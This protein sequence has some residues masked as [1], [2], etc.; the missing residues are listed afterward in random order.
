VKMNEQLY[1]TFLEEMQAL[2][3]FR[4]GYAAEHPTTP[5]QPDDPDVRRMVE[6]LAFFSARSRQASL[7]TLLTHRLRLFRQFLPYLLDPLPAMGMLQAIPT[8]KLAEPVELPRGTE[9]AVR[10]PAERTAIFRTLRP[11]RLL[12]LSLGRLSTLVLPDGRL[13]FTL[14]ATTSHPRNDEIG[15]LAIHVNHLNDFHGSLKVL[16][17]LERHLDRVSVSFDERVDGETRGAPCQIAFAGADDQDGWHPL[18]RERLYFHF[19][20]AES[21]FDVTLPSPPRN[22]QRFTLMF[23]VRPEWPQH[24]RLGA[25]TFQLFATPIINLARASAQPILHDGTRE[26]WPIRHPA[27]AGKYALHSVRGVYRAAET[28]LVPL[29]AATVARGAGAYEIADEP[30]RDGKREPALL[31]H[32]P[33]ALGAPTTM[34][35]DAEWHQPWFASAIGQPLQIAPY[36]RALAGVEWELSGDLVP[37]R[38]AQIG[39]AVDDFTHILVLQHRNELSREDVDELLQVMGSVW[40]GPFASIRELIADVR[41]LETPVTHRER[42]AG[43]K[44]IYQL[45]L[46]EHEPGMHALIERFARHLER[47]LSEWL[48]GAAVEV[49]VGSR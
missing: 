43:S 19:P 12:P 26:R 22:W 24:L 35:V 45:T 48:A 21:F 41:V 47:V 11:L 20:R 36:R 2:E 3:S 44:R 6:A 29:R 18:L 8:G 5:L 31:L 34:S 46:E 13:R 32:M 7:A 39:G 23:D 40:S 42:G 15:P 1:K 16:S 30:R 27:P 38:E 37:H 25:D 28:G 17:A 33:E 10:D 14:P 4:M 9:I 49:R